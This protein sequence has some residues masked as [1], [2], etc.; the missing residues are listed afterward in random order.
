MS[1]RKPDSEKRSPRR[2]LGAK[3]PSAP[4]LCGWAAVLSGT[5]AI[6]VANYLLLTPEKI[7]FRT[8][9]SFFWDGM[10][11]VLFGQIPNVDFPTPVGPLNYWGPALL[12]KLNRKVAEL[13]QKGRAR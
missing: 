1:L 11:R 12:N 5:L 10:H 4:G 7:L 8:D 3:G 6:Y 9:V 13:V 2:L